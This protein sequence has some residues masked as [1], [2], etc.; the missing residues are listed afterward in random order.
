MALDGGVDRAP[1][2][3]N[4]VADGEVLAGNRALGELPYQ[5]CVRRQRLRDEQ[6][7]ARVLVEP[8]NNARTGQ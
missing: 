2:G 8:M 3:Q 6:Q 4:T 1:A 7:S 5:R